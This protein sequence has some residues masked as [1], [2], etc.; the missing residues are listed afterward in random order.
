MKQAGDRIDL[1]FNIK[2]LI[3]G[4]ETEITFGDL[5]QRRTVIS[6][7]MKNNTPGCDRQIDALVAEHEWFNPKGYAIIAISKDGCRSH[8]NYAKKK[9]I[10]FTLVSDPEYKFAHRTD[11][12]IQKKMFGKNYTGPSRSAFV[13]DKDGTILEA[14]EKIDTKSHAEEL[15][16]II[17][18]LN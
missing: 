16:R 15:K 13:I 7:Y 2:A 8:Q 14:I 10:G 11:S 5:V 6:V 1:N 12:I 3:D 9:G 18:G 17:E 4:K